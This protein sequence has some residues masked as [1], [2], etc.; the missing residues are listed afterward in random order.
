MAKTKVRDRTRALDLNETITGTKSDG[1]AE[2][3]LKT[4]QANLAQNKA[5]KEYKELR[6]EL[7]GKMKAAKL[8]KKV[9]EMIELVPGGERVTLEAV[10]AAPEHEKANVRKLV[11]LVDPQTF[12]NIVSA[13]KDAI[14]TLAGEAVFQQ[15]KEPVTGEEN[16]SVKLLK[17]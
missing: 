1:L 6:K 16:V 9:F 10:V 8:T 11:K 14:V 5:Q 13:T 3:A 17:E 12:L 4:F 7:L 15:C 2:L